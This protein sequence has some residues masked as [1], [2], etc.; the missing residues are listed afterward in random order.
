MDNNG[1]HSICYVLGRFANDLLAHV[2]GLVMHS[3]SVF[4]WTGQVICI[5]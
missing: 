4:C 5:I 1:N 3:V 2:M